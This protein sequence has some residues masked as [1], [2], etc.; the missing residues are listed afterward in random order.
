MPKNRW[1]DHV[2]RPG[3]IEIVDIDSGAAIKFGYFAG[4]GAFIVVTLAFFGWVF[5]EWLSGKY[6]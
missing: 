4:F 5:G 2:C 6:L 3:E 1:K